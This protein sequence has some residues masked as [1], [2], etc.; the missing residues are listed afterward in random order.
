[1]F[2]RT[3]WLLIVVI[4]FCGRAAGAEPTPA[5]LYKQT[6]HSV[7]WVITPA[8]AKGTGFVVDRDHRWLITNYHV[9]GESDSVDVIFPDFLEGRLITERSH[10]T[11]GLARLRKS[12]RAV[13]GRVVRTDARRDLAL[14]E[15]EVL[16]ADVT[17]LTI[18]AGPPAP[19]EELLS[20]GNRR[21]LDENWIATTGY[22]RQTFRTEEGYFWNAKPLAKGAGMLLAQSPILEGDSGGPVVD[23]RGEVVGVA[24]AVRWQTRLASL[25]VDAD[26]LRAFLG[27]KESDTKAERPATPGV[28]VYRDSLRAL[29]LIRNASSNSRSTAWV[30]DRERKLLLTAGTA[31][32]SR[33]VVDVIFPVVRD[34]RLISEARFYRDSLRE[35]RSSGQAQRGCVLARDLGRN[36]ALVEVEALTE[37]TVALTLAEAAPDPAEHLHVIGN[38][39]GVEAVWVYAAGTVRQLGKARVSSDADAAAVRVVLAQLPLGDGDAG[40]PVLDD[41]GRVI[42]VAMG[43]DAPQQLVSFLL[44]AVEVREFLVVTK[45]LREPKTAVDFERRAEL[46]ARLH[47]WPRVVADLDESLKREAKNATTLAERGHAHLI[48]GHIDLALNDCEA[49]VRLDP[50]SAIA[51]CRRAEVLGFRGDLAAALAGCDEALRL[52]PKSALAF[53]VRSE[54]HRK[55]GAIDRAI[56]DSTEAIWIDANLALAYHAR[57]LGYANKGEFEKSVA[58]H[59]RATTLDPSWSFAAV[60]LG[61][62]FRQQGEVEK[63]IKAY[64]RAL[65]IDPT[66]GL[67]HLRRGAAWGTKAEEEK[68]ASDMAEAVRLRPTLLGEAVTEIERRGTEL[69]KR[70]DMVG[71]VRWYRRSL[72]ALRQ[73]S[74]LAKRIDAGI[75]AAQKEPDDQRRAAALRTFLGTLRE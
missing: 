47:R 4:P 55:K 31:V 60:A 13:N 24:S 51:H 73:Q 3:Y 74:D 5:A 12:G 6:L 52:A 22:L 33:D 20:I 39:N 45:S 54:I 10:Y 37:K 9:V 69:A 23:R 43:K 48:L 11:D 68:A 36:L 49:A 29:A 72:Q 28:A 44:D 75:Q 38:P 16:P 70:D 30:V 26:E 7:A 18:A 71:C 50:K 15:L 67:T 27:H 35:L 66:D 42:G 64:D 53:A 19:G 65:E 63:A 46:Y 40:S 1:M 62:V 34:G 2:R 57:G 25:C 21:D 32:G 41:Q 14:V 17:A 61:D 58:D 56:T 8:K 59:E